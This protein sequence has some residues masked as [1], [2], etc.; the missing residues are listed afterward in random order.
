MDF[1]LVASIGLLFF[2]GKNNGSKKNIDWLDE[3]Q[4]RLEKMD[5]MSWSNINFSRYLQPLE[6]IFNPSTYY[7][8]DLKWKKV[9][10]Q[11]GRYSS[12]PITAE[13]ATR[14]YTY[15]NYIRGGIGYIGRTNLNTNYNS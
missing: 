12:D 6:A 2:V 9:R 10:T 3:P 8:D 11:L 15:L 1:F 14:D 5:G 4:K 7:T 13:K